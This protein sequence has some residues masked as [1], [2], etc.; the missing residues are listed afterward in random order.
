L[1]PLDYSIWGEFAKTINWK[2]VTSKDTLIEELKR[3]VKKF[4][5]D[6]AVQSCS[7]WTVHLK[8]VLENDGYYLH[9]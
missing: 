3:A 8:R 1:N 6:V 9:K 2:K 7:S 4:R 5:Q